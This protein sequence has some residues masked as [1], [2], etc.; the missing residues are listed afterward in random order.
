MK[1]TLETVVLSSRVMTVAQIEQA[2]PGFKGRIRGLVLRADAGLPGFAGLRD[3]VIRVGRSLYVDEPR[4]L[5][6]VDSHR[7]APPSPPRSASGRRGRER[8]GHVS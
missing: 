3:A 4:F 6:W 1:L 5:A 8:G 7:S 2:H